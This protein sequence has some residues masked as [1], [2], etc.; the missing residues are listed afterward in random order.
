MTKMGAIISYGILNAAG[1]N[2]TISLGSKSGNNRCGA[3]V[4]MTMFMQ[5]WYWHSL[6]YF[7]PLCLSSTSLIGVTD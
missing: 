3:I 4:G 7:F 5:F 6:M 2:A 1:R